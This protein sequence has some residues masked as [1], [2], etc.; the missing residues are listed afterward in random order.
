MHSITI[1][2]KRRST[3]ADAVAFHRVT[4]L[5]R[6]SGALIGVISDC[7]SVAWHGG[8]ARHAPAR[9]AIASAAGNAPTT[10]KSRYMPCHRRKLSVAPPRSRVFQISSGFG[11][12]TSREA[13]LC[14]WR[15]RL[16]S[17]YTVST[18]VSHSS[19]NTINLLETCSR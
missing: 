7:M 17:L 8:P 6:E 2:R 19:F 14:S 18:Y 3:A 15:T 11:R 16:M 9:S 12:G 5:P 4:A 13:L 1:N 10:D